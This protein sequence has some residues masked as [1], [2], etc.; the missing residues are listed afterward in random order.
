ME[1]IK[2]RKNQNADFYF[3][4]LVRSY[5]L[6]RL[7]VRSLLHFIGRTEPFKKR[8]EFIA[9]GADFFPEHI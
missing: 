3:C 2:T 7:T 8:P 1:C 4:A 9:L 6:E 5:K